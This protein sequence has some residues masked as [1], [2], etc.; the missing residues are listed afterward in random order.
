MELESVHNNVKLL[1]EMLDSYNQNETRPED[2][3]LMK[4][5]HQACERLKPTVLRLANETQDNEEMLGKYFI[6]FFFLN[7][8]V[9]NNFDSIVQH[10][11]QF[12]TIFLY[13]NEKLFLYYFL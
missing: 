8:N 6:L 11:V 1:S 7:N 3:E 9:T 13:N 5:L 12:I 4:E 10:F 2:I